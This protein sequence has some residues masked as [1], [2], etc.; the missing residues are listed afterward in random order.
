MVSEVYRELNRFPFCIWC[1][2][3]GLGN[4]SRLTK[5]R[6]FMRFVRKITFFDGIYVVRYSGIINFTYIG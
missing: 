1:L 5:N 4:Q 2:F 6:P 3:A